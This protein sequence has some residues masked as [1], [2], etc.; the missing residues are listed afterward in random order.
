MKVC[1]FGAGGVGGYFGGRLAL[2]GVDV[3]LVARGQ[4]LEALKAAGLRVRSVFGDFH[5]DV[6]AT[7]D[8]GAVGA[9]D[10][11]LF[12][13]KSYDTASAAEQLHPLIGAD[14]AVVSLQNGIDNEEKLAD[15]LGW[16]HVMGGVAYIFSNIAEPGVIEHVGGPSSLVFGEL[17]G[18]DSPR[19]RQ[20][21]QACETAGIDATLSLS[22][23]EVLWTK[24]AFIC[25]LSGITA[26]T[27]LPMDR[28]RP[29]CV[30]LTE[31]TST[32]TNQRRTSDRLSGAHNRR[33]RPA[34]SS[35]ADA[36][37][38]CQD[39]TGIRRS[40]HVVERSTSG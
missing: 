30:R 1:V 28:D 36:L 4:H 14:T 9:C 5:V 23:R 6:A 3:H 24:F 39:P 26:S 13:V 37:R 33:L 19:S 8:P 22:V 20:L 25:A 10:V 35:H 40:D 38:R 32:R 34:C 7:D 21:L 15:V 31:A 11:V 2:S 27:Q 17:D 12:T 29:S 18:R 16:E